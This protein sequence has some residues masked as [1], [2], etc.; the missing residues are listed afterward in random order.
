M[1][2]FLKWSL[3]THQWLLQ[4]S[5][6]NVWDVFGW[7]NV[8]LR[9]TN[10]FWMR[11]FSY[12]TSDI[13]KRSISR[14]Q[15]SVKNGKHLF[16]WKHVFWPYEKLLLIRRR[17]LTLSTLR[18]DSANYIA[19]VFLVF[20]RKQCLTFHARQFVWNVRFCFLGKKKKKNERKKKNISKTPS[21]E[22][23]AFKISCHTASC[24]YNYRMKWMLQLCE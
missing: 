4:A 11:C 10:Y 19:Y 21:A 5:K 23:F 24:I 13:V 9:L 7:V 18:T 22:I 2:E 12:S 17:V 6:N 20:Q 8:R 1:H 16:L 15:L 3:C 14:D